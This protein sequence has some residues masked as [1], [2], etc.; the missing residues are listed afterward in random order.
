MGR[1]ALAILLVN[2]GHSRRQVADLLQAARSSVNGWCQRY[3]Q[4][5]IEGLYD[6]RP[7]K[8]PT[9]PAHLITRLLLI[10]VQY[11]PQEF[12]YL[13]SRWSTE[14][15][16]LLVQEFLNIRVHSS[17]LRR[18]LP[19][20]GI[21]WRRAA[22]TLR[23][24]DPDKDSKL[25]AIK[26]ALATCS[27][28]HP[29]FYED[30]VDIHLNPK[31]GADWGERGQ[32]RKVATPGKNRKYYLAGALHAGNGKVS[33]VGSDSKSSDLFIAMLRKLRGQYRRARTIT[34]IV[35][36]Y[37]IHKSRKTQRWLKANPKF[38]LV[39]QPVYS[40]WVNK[41]EKLWH[42]LHET[43]TRNHQ[44]KAMWALLEQVKHF[45]AAASPFPGNG[46]GLVKVA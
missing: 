25:A 46:H 4:A 32:Q 9:L 34:L 39:F 1:R 22:P 10:L 28:D 44:C 12:G 21:V 45:I 31:I 30:E 23:I 37:I 26:E 15:F 40:P 43:V 13:R 42:A 16:S 5:G 36:N 41:I 2:Q 3:E 18:W 35:D 24:K 33:Y 29:V 27:I 17:T 11:S 14:L 6:A 19:K 20:L 7:G 38:R 8:S